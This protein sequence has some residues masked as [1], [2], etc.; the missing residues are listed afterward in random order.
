M[1]SGQLAASSYRDPAGFVYEDNGCILRQ[2]NREA[3]Q[4]YDRLM[5]SG[6]YRELTERGLLIRHEETDEPPR[7]AA[8]AY[9]ILRPQYIAF[10]SYPYE[11]SFSQNKDAALL[12]LEIQRRAIRNGLTLKDA[13]AYNVQFQDGRPIFIDTLSLELYR[14]G[15]PWRAYRQ[16]CQ[17]FLAPLALMCLTDIRLGQLCRTNI[18]GIPLNLAARLLPA[19][20]RLRLGLLLHVHLHGV[21]QGSAASRNMAQPVRRFHRT[22]MLGLIDSLESAIQRLTW[23]PRESDWSSYYDHTT[24]SPSATAAKL[25]AVA[26]FLDVVRPKCV[27][28]LGANTGQ[29]SRL[30]SDRGAFTMSFDIDPNCVELNY[31]E[32]KSRQ[33]T[34]IL[35]LLM[36]LLNP[37]PASGWINQERFSILQRG[38]PDMV[39]ALALIHHLAISGNLPLEQIARFFYS[40]TPWVAIEFVA[41]TDSQVQLL[42]AQRGH[43]H[44]PYDQSSFEQCFCR[45]FL[46]QATRPTLPGSRIL[47]LLRRRSLDGSLPG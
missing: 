1:M 22:A 36:D 23:K 45:Y 46:I 5:S 43:V 25:R 12:T 16:F 42:A 13:S 33:E 17:H 10:I 21:L 20:S 39:L 44:H 11:W 7:V 15:E 4:S 40:L 18:D 31:L 34:R 38:Q 14:E 19:K 47:Y 6:L 26:E 35:P 3:Q 32:M 27:W 2:V 29:F 28:D 9:K 30:A 24:Y 41:P 8:T 37:S